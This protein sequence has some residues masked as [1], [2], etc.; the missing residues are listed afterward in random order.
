MKK[1]SKRRAM[2]GGLV[3]CTAESRAKTDSVSREDLQGIAL[4]VL[5]R[6]Y[7]A[8]RDKPENQRDRLDRKIPHAR[9]DDGDPSLGPIVLPLTT[10]YRP[11]TSCH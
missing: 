9:L 10:D 2:G 6:L 4:H 5:E 11:L 1:F 3:M 7:C 8:S